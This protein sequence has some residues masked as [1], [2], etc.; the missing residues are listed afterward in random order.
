MFCAGPN[1]KQEHP[2]DGAM[3]A[4]KTFEFKNSVKTNGS[5]HSLRVE[6]LG[7]TL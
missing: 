6:Q 4:R 2:V 7:V 5:V 3:V 1:R